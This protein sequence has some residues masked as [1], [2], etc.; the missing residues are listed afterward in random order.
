MTFAPTLM[1]FVGAFVVATGLGLGWALGTYAMGR[2]LS[3][4]P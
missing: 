3:K 2:L 4:L 1:N